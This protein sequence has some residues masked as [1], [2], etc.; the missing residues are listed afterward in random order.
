VRDHDHHDHQLDRSLVRYDDHDHGPDHDVRVW[1]RRRP[2]P[3]HPADDD[4]HD[5]SPLT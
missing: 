3:R 4:H 5:H 1:P 2:S